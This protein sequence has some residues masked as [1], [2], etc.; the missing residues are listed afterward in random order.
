MKIEK[1]KYWF[2]PMALFGVSALVAVVMLLWNGLMPEI[3]R[4]PTISFWQA[5]G[6]L[7]LCKLLFGS[8]GG[9]HWGHR[10]KFGAYGKHNRMHERWMTMSEEERTEF[11][12]RR[13]DH[14]HHHPFGR[15]D[16][17][18]KGCGPANKDEKTGN[19]QQ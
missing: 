17:F 16:G 15:R 5:A 7:L 14:F 8:F 19:N 4:L 11:I 10:R 6:L 1:R 2:I 18:G 3:F 12:N 13:M 9:Q